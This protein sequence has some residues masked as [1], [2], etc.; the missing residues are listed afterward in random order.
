[1][2]KAL[3][4]FSFFLVFYNSEAQKWGAE[5]TI[6]YNLLKPMGEMKE[7]IDRADGLNMEFFMNS[8]NKR[9][10]L[11]LEVC[12]ANYGAVDFPVMF[13][14]A[15]VVTQKDVRIFSQIYNTFLTGRYYL[16]TEGPFLPYV[17]LKAGFSCFATSLRVEK[18]DGGDFF[19]MSDVEVEDLHCSGTFAMSVGGG[20]KADLSYIFKKLKSQSLLLDFSCSYIGGGSVTYLNPSAPRITSNDISKEIRYNKYVQ[21][22]QGT[23][24]VNN[25]GNIHN[26][27]A[28]MLDFR[29]GICVR[30]AGWKCKS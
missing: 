13:N 26:S 2:K 23:V 5:M 16:K 22:D 25:I 17:S 30:M 12:F 1:M 18:E 7:R 20:V 24:H 21:T 14:N 10:S 6:G 11:G 29:I 27:M 19:C 28:R 4:I 9:Y 3:L 15:E 8:P